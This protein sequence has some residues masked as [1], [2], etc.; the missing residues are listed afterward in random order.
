MISNL[1]TLDGIADAF[2]DARTFMSENQRKGNRK[3]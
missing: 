2:D 1:D 3:S